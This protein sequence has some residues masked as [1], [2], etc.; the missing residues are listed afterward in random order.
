MWARLHD[1]LRDRARVRAGRSPTPTPAVL[2]SASVRGADTVPARSAPA[3][4][5]RPALGGR[6]GRPGGSRGRVSEELDVPRALLRP[7]GHVAW[8]GEDQQ[9][10]LRG[11]APPPIDQLPPRVHVIESPLGHT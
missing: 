1:A 9:D 11:S 4:P 10:L 6:L 5:D 7:D 3:G 2:D 8:V